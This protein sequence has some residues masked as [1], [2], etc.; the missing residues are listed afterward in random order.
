MKGDKY[1]FFLNIGAINRTSRD[2]VSPVRRIFFFFQINLVLHL[3]LDLRLSP[4]NG[5]EE[6]LGKV[7]QFPPDQPDNINLNK[8]KIRS[9]SCFQFPSVELD[10]ISP[11]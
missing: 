6:K 7:I 4:V 3:Y 8:T 5:L 2:S 1:V 11:I 10:E 9:S